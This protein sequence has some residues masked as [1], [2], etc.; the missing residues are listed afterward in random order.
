MFAKGSRS[1]EYLQKVLLISQLCPNARMLSGVWQWVLPQSFHDAIS[2]LYGA[3]LQ[4]LLWD[5]TGHASP[6]TP[7]IR[8]PSTNVNRRLSQAYRNEFDRLEKLDQQMKLDF[9][10]R[11][12][13]PQQMRKPQL[14]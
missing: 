9:Q 8:F 13:F 1:I 10:K 12:W 7:S 11:K 2:R 4:W 5:E 14:P 3:S 6:P